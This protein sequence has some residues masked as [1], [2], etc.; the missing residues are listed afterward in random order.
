MYV[1]ICLHVKYPLFLLDLRQT[2][3]FRQTFEESSNV[4]FRKNPSSG[5]RIIHADGQTHRCDEA[6]IRFLQFCQKRLLTAKN[7][8]TV[9]IGIF[10]Y[11]MAVG[12]TRPFVLTGSVLGTKEVRK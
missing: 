3:L 12:L 11:G 5:S 8:A 1:H 10:G 2:W 7:V 4:K 6:N 9:L